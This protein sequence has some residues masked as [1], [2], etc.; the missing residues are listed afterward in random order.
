MTIILDL[1]FYWSSVGVILTSLG[2]I[3]GFRRLKTLL[4]R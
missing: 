4:S 2:G 1:D 3:W